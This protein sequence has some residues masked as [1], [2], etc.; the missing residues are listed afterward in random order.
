M[1]DAESI[2]VGPCRLEVEHRAGGPRGGP[3][4]RLRDGEGRERLRFDCFVDGAHWHLDPAGADVREPIPGPGDPI[5]WVLDELRRDLPAWLTRAG[6][7]AAAA[8]DQGAAA[9]PRV[10]RALRNP[11]PDL[12]GVDEAVKR[13]SAGEKWRQYPQDVLPLWVADMDFPLADP[14]RR[15][16]QRH[17][18]HAD[19]VYPVHPAPTDVPDLFVDWM[20]RRFDCEIDPSQVEL[21][22]DVMQGLYVAVDRF[23]DEGDGVVC[24]LPIYPPFLHALRELRRRRVDW[25]YVAS[26]AGY[27]PDTERLAAEV[28]ERT[29]I[30]LLCNPHNPTGQ[31]LDRAELEALGELVLARD[32]LVVADEI[33][34]DLV[35]AGHRHLPFASLAP[36]L[37][38]RT[39][40]LTAASK[41]FNIAGLRCAVAHF[42]TPE[43][44]KRFCE[45]PRKIRGGLG[46]LGIEATRAAWRHG[47]PWLEAVLRYLGANRDRVADFARERLPG[48]V[49]HPPDATYFAWLDCRALALEPSAYQ[50]FLEQGKLALSPG[51]AFTPAGD[52]FVR[53]NFATSRAIL[54]DGLERMAA[55]LSRL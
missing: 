12:D 35:Y 24:P 20:R 29:R 55:A 42:G 47:E 8:G 37:A 15:A 21:L 46:I 19:L 10:E 9:L 27:V 30:L 16:L 23:S 53:L 22:T 44:R 26:D 33:H 40:T 52:G 13:Q 51:R 32:L 4:L 49:F 43:L 54:D 14:I 11:A 39:I 45:V 50:F 2:V 6:L 31:A 34:M 5:D 28:D 7:D 36:E 25:H 41:S 17:L 3:T 1:S 38:A 18:D 48:V